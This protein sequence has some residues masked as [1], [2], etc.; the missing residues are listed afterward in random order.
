MKTERAE[1]E[2]FIDGLFRRTMG[3]TIEEEIQ[4]GLLQPIATFDE[5][6]EVNEGEIFTW[7]MLK[8]KA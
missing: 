3:I 4:R 6:V 7:K 8:G 2:I 1:V 5:P